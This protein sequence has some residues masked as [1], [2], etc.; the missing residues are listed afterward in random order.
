[1]G[2]C[3]VVGYKDERILLVAALATF[4]L[5]VLVRALWVTLPFRGLRYYTNVNGTGGEQLAT[6]KKLNLMANKIKPL[7]LKTHNSVMA[8]HMLMVYHPIPPS[9][10]V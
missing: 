8:G 4:S 5:T 7:E 1:M 3:I 2:Y 10:S 6:N 9:Q